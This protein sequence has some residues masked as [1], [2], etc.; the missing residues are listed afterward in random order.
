[1]AHGEERDTTILREHTELPR[2]IESLIEARTAD[3]LFV[4]DPEY[5]IVRWDARAESLTGLLAQ[6][7]AGTYLGS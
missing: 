3:A 6:D 5:S 4:V 1:M 7:V 2:T